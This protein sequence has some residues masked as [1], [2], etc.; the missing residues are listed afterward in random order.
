ILCSGGAGGGGGAGDDDGGGTSNQFEDGFADDYDDGGGGGGGGGGFLGFACRGD[1]TLGNIDT[2]DPMDPN[3]TVVWA[4][5]IRCVGGRGGSTYDENFISGN[6]PSPTSLDGN[7]GQG[8]AGGGGG[9]GGIALICGGDM[10]VRAMECYA[11]GK[12]GGN[13]LFIEGG[14]RFAVDEAGAGG[15]GKI[16]MAD[17]DGFGSGEVLNN[18][19]VFLT[20]DPNRPGLTF[21]EAKD[22]AEMAGTV[23]ISFGVWGDELRESMFGPT[24]IVSECF[25]TLSDS[26]S[27]DSALVLWN[28]PRFPYS[29]GTPALRTMRIFIDTVKAGLGGLP[30]IPTVE[31]PDGSFT[32]NPAVGF[33]Q[34]V[35]AADAAVPVAYQ[36]TT[37]LPAGAGSLGKRFV[38]VRIVFDP[39]L[40]STNPD[41]LLGPAPLGFAPAGGPVLPIA[42]DPATPGLEN[43]RGNLD[44]AP[45]GVPAIAELR[46]TFTP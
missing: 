13:S 7:I 29:S 45:Q 18:P 4:A 20:P 43:N 23:T 35:P 15:G 21:D 39:T 25:D 46:V 16:Y 41:E 11:F 40:I 14:D 12:R 33:T 42:D 34:E 31:A 5:V 3:D 30:D 44:T 27:Y 26:T 32:L 19:F 1:V 22:F 8:E 38:R 9:G 6:P 2:G 10:T 36:M 37:V 17:Q 28:A 24:Q